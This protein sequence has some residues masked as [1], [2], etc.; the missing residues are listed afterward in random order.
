MECRRET[1]LGTQR[2]NKPVPETSARADGLAQ[3]SLEEP[4]AGNL[5]VRVRGG[6]GVKAPALPGIM[7]I[8]SFKPSERVKSEGVGPSIL[9]F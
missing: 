4:Y 7:T 9:I 1:G 3:P 5:L 6:A 2:P 8:Q